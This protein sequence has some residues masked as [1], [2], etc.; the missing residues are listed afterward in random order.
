MSTNVVPNSDEDDIESC[1]GMRMI[2]NFSR[3]E[4]QQTGEHGHFSCIG[5]YEAD[6]DMALVMETA[7]FKYPPFWVPTSLLY[8]AMLST[9]PDSGFSRGYLLVERKEENIT[10]EPQPDHSC[11]HHNMNSD[12]CGCNRSGLVTEG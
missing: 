3:K 8:K 1:S 6:S 7:R 11:G 9:D 10:L 4:L 2:V 12:K 5:A